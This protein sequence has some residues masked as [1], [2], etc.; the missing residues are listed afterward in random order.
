MGKGEKQGLITRRRVRKG[1]KGDGRGEMRR[2]RIPENMRVRKG[3][4]DGEE[5]EGGGGMEKEDGRERERD[6]GT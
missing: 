3:K 1:A 6:G 2:V 4:G 5:R